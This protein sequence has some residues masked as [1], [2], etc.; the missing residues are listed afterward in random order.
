MKLQS[1]I[2]RWAAGFGLMFSSIPMIMIIGWLDIPQPASNWLCVGALCL[3]MAA[4]LYIWHG[5]EKQ[6][7]LDSGRVI[8]KACRQ[9]QR[10]GLSTLL[11]VDSH[12]P[13]QYQ[14]FLRDDQGREGV[15]W[16]DKPTFERHPLE[17]TYTKQ[18]APA[19][20][21]AS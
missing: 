5:T 11:S 6:P 4:G 2:G 16:V 9:P 7:E 19:T 3:A 8:R 20:R 15:A 10:F 17:S 21:A 13:V 1:N 14:L 12:L 18:P